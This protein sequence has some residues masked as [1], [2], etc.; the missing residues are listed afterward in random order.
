[1]SLI[2]L[3]A[4]ELSEKLNKKEIKAAEIAKEYLGQIK[5]VDK[6]ISAYVTIMEEAALAAEASASHALDD[7]QR[8]PPDTIFNAALGPV[9]ATI[10]RGDDQNAPDGFFED[11]LTL[12]SDG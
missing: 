4:H 5:K 11:D 8:L 3:N 2:N 10:L 1:M 9:E 6:K 12:K 7:E